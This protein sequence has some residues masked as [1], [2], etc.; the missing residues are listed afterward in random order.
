MLIKVIKHDAFNKTITTTNFDYLK[1]GEKQPHTE[2]GKESGLLL[3][4]KKSDKT[5]GVPM[6]TQAQD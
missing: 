6:K 4:T 2:H 1:E 3:P 5:K